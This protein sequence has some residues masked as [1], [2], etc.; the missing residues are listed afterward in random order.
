MLG[1]LEDRL[2]E[3]QQ[4]ARAAEEAS[5]RLKEELAQQEAAFSERASSTDKELASLRTSLADL[6]SKTATQASECVSSLVQMQSQMMHLQVNSPDNS[7]GVAAADRAAR[8]VS[9]GNPSS[10]L[11]H[12]ANGV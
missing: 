7:P 4:E 2:A 11:A 6:W 5:C 8:Q 10:G 12:T 9:F 1:L 3:S